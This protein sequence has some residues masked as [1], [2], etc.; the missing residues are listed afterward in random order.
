LGFIVGKG[1]VAE[2]TS[3]RIEGHCK[4]IGLFGAEEFLQSIDETKDRGGVFAF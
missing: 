4:K 3:R 2:G 1:F